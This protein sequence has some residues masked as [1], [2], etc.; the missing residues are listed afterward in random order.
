LSIGDVAAR[1]GVPVGTLRTWEARYGVPAPQ[2]EIGGH[3]R[4]STADVE[5]V[6]ETV[7]QRANGLAMPVAVERAKGQRQP[8]DSSVFAGLRNGHAELTVQ[9]LRK[10]TLLA[11]C[12]AIEDECC[13]QANRPLLFASFQRERHYRA[14]EGR[15]QDLAATARGAFVMADFEE[16][17]PASARPIEIAVPSNASL[18]RE[19]VLVC[20]A[21]DHPGCLVGWEAPGQ[22]QR[23]DRFRRFDTLWSLDAAVVRDAARICAGL[24]QQYRPEVSFPFSDELEELTPQLSAADRRASHVFDRM[25]AYFSASLDS[26]GAPVD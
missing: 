1:T 9:S 5:L 6:L 11:L 15:W 4:Y 8:S 24:V 25:L 19:W 22:R 13:A 17:G 26:G 18:N 7:R 2:R 14:S 12:R 16:P 3:R 21:E 23:P 20:D 10:P